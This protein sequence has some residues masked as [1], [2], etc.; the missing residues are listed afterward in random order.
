[1]STKVVLVPSQVKAYCKVNK[2]CTSEH[3]E[4]SETVAAG[5]QMEWM[6]TVLNIE[7]NITHINF[8]ILPLQTGKPPHSQR[9]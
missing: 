7:T 4:E 3:V 8:K 1:M 9:V 2:V 6:T 5:S